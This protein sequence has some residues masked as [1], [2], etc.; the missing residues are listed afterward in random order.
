[1]HFPSCHLQISLLPQQ[2]PT[3][4]LFCSRLEWMNEFMM[5]LLHL[6]FLFVTSIVIMRTGQV[7]NAV[8]GRTWL[9]V[10]IWGRYHAHAGAQAS[11]CMQAG[12]WA[13]RLS[14]LR[15]RE[16]ERKSSI[17]EQD[18]STSK[19]SLHTHLTAG[20]RHRRNALHGVPAQRS[21]RQG[22]LAEGMLSGTSLQTRFNATGWEPFLIRESLSECDPQHFQTDSLSCAAWA[23]LG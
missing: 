12:E 5:F 20:G 17:R 18:W 13:Q 10:P 22:M 2:K 14:T 19:S 16:R 7:D 11:A 4:T 23:W 21:Q 1:M 6:H 8:S 15:E 9:I 3:H